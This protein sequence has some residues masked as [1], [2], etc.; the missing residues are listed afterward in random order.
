MKKASISISVFGLLLGIGIIVVVRAIDRGLQD[1]VNYLHGAVQSSARY[2][3]NVANA[4]ASNP[5]ALTSTHEIPT[6]APQTS[7]SSNTYFPHQVKG[8]R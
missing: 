3:T 1:S 4:A 6:N 5:K 8:S 2:L 7:V